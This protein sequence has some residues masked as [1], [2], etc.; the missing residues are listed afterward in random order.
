MGPREVGRMGASWELPHRGTCREV[1]CIAERG[2]V[3]RIAECRD[4]IRSRDQERAVRR[5]QRPESHNLAHKTR[6]ESQPFR[7]RHK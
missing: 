3:A 4:L 2:E 6:R 5:R 1:N 7:Q